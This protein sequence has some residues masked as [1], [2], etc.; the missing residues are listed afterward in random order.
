MHIVI[1]SPTL[2]QLHA[3]GSLKQLGINFNQELITK[4]KDVVHCERVDGVEIDESELNSM[5]EMLREASH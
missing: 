5:E 3:L 2:N 4:L 1:P